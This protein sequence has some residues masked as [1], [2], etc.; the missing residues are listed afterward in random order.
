MLLQC[1]E[2]AYDTCIACCELLHRLTH[3]WVRTPVRFDICSRT[4]LDIN[5]HVCQDQTRF[6]YPVAWHAISAMHLPVFRAHFWLRSGWR[7][8]T[9]VSSTPHGQRKVGKGAAACE[10]AFIL[11]R[12]A[13]MLQA[14]VALRTL[15]FLRCRA[16]TSHVAFPPFCAISQQTH[17]GLRRCLVSFP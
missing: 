10:Q 5:K 1:S 7:G 9:H 12:T 13:V 15:L 4:L 2:C 11:L 6:R 8:S 17:D 3:V 16:T 14:F